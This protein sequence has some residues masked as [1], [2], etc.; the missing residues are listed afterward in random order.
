VFRTIEPKVSEILT[1]RKL[2]IV[3][4]EEITKF[5]RF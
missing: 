3:K 5:E 4:P 2:K 1:A